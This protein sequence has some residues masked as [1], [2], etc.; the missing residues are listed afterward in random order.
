MR[1]RIRG[2][3]HLMPRIASGFCRAALSLADARRPAVSY[4][5]VG[6]TG[7]GKSLSFEL[8]CD[9]TF[10]PG[11]LAIFDM[12]EYQ[13]RSAVNKL[14]GEDRDDPGLLGRTLNELPSGALLFDEI[15]KAHS[16]VMDLFLQILWRGCITVATG[17]TFPMGGYVIGFTSNIGA[18]DAMRMA[19]STLAS[20]EHA[21]LRRVGQSLRPELIGRLDEQLVF[22]RLA[23]EV[24]REICALEVAAEAARL[25]GQGYDLSVTPEAMEF[26][27]RE[28]FHPELGAR[29]LRKTVGRELQG[30][31][32]RALFA[33]GTACGKV[34][35]DSAQPRL[36]IIG[37]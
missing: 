26:L 28:G 7:T 11:R 16:L 15:E 36:K 8:A 13:D 17:R 5:L 31:V 6:P 29:P 2:Q 18:A 27:M 23:P 20:I 30:A 35:P 1:S 32:M 25:R 10:G 21:T 19:N 22:G 9:Y 14:I 24:Q 34:V 33:S 3:D 37:G 12:T 4:L